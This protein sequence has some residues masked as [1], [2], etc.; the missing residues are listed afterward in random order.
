MINATKC[1]AIGY[2]RVSGS[3]R[4]WSYV[5]T[6]EYKHYTTKKGDLVWKL[7]EVYFRARRSFQKCERESKELARELGCLYIENIRQWDRVDGGNNNGR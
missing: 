1:I 5:Q 7:S 6:V 3:A 2:G 4:N